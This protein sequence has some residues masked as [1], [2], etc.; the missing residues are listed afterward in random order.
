MLEIYRSRVLRRKCRYNKS[1]GSLRSIV[2]GNVWNIR[3]FFAIFKNT[4]NG[5]T[6]ATA[7]NSPHFPLFFNKSPH[8][9]CFHFSNVP[10]FCL[11]RDKKMLRKD[12]LKDGKNVPVPAAPSLRTA[13][14]WRE[15]E[16]VAVSSRR[17]STSS[18]MSSGSR[19]RRVTSPPPPPPWPPPPPGLVEAEYMNTEPYPC[20]DCRG[21]LTPPTSPTGP[22]AFKFYVYVNIPNTLPQN[23]CLNVSC[24]G[25]KYSTRYLYFDA[26]V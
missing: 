23:I 2:S 10:L 24:I 13:S 26:K 12:V 14:P 1:P 4:V 18:G 9:I 22:C 17:A 25:Y 6:R 3:A 15:M 21:S 8:C 11:V 7:N 16:R 20:R 5:D 19:R